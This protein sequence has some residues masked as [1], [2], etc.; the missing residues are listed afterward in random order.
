VSARNTL[1]TLI[2]A[3]D[4]TGARGSIALVSE[5]GVLEEVELDS[6]DGFAHVLFGEIEA[7]LAR[8]R[9]A[10][11]DIAAFASASG[12]GSFTGVRIGLT[13][14][15]G[16]AEATGRPVV[17]VSNLQA[18]AS[19]G[20][21]PLRAVA[22]DARRGEIYGAVYNAELE[23]VQEEIVTKFDVWM[24]SLPKGELEFI[25]IKV[26]SVDG[27]PAEAGVRAPVFDSLRALAGAIGRIALDR[28]QRGLAQD[29]AEI[30]A[31]YVRRSDAEL[32]WKDPSLGKGSRA[33]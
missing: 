33:R 24:S 5:A 17:A 26:I 25:G 32:L 20:A 6:P 27:P 28:F 3:I 2:L 14:A 15:K 8:A 11:G 29:P 21:G 13:A 23:P 16:L 9:V 22:I 31:N 19:F 10:I 4:T 30:D 12:P 1:D 7:L 18:L